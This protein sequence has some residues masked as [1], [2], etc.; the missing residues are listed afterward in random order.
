MVLSN[1]ELV[2]RVGRAE[3]FWN[4]GQYLRAFHAYRDLL[5]DVVQGK[6]DLREA[7]YNEYL[8]MDRVGDIAVLVGYTAVAI[9]LYNRLLHQAGDPV[10]AAMAAFKRLYV[11]TETGDSEPARQ[12]LTWICRRFWNGELLNPMVPD[13]LDR[14]ERSVTWPALERPA[15]FAQLYLAL[16][17]LYNALQKIEP[18]R[19]WLERGLRHAKGS[20]R[21][22]IAAVPLRIAMARHHLM[23]GDFER[24]RQSLVDARTEAMANGAGAAYALWI[25]TEELRL[26]LTQGRFSA[27]IASLKNMEGECRKHGLNRALCGVLLGRAE[28][29]I[30]LNLLEETDACLEQIHALAQSPGLED[31]RSEWVRIR[32]LRRLR[33]HVFGSQ[34]GSEAVIEMQ[35]PSEGSG[36]A[37][38]D[39]EADLRDDGV[40]WTGDCLRDYE[41]KETRFYLALDRAARSAA[42]P[43]QFLDVQ[44]IL[45]EIRE[46]FSNLPCSLIQARL[47]VLRGLVHEAC[48]RDASARSEFEQACQTFRQIGAHR[49]LFHASLHLARSVR[50]ESPALFEALVRENELRIDRLAEGLSPEMQNAFRVNKYTLV[51]EQR[52]IRVEEVV[53]LRAGCLK[54][55]WPSRLLAFIRFV[56]SLSDFIGE[57]DDE[58]LSRRKAASK[59]PSCK[60]LLGVVRRWLRHPARNMSVGYVVLPDRTFTYAVSKWRLECQVVPV[61]RL[62]IAEY[63]RQLHEALVEGPQLQYA[64]LAHR[65]CTALGLEQFLAFASKRINSLTVVPDEELAVLPFSALRF[66]RS[67]ERPQYVVE[68]FAVNIDDV[69]SR[70]RRANRESSPP[71]VAYYSG[72]EDEDSVLPCAR[73]ASGNAAEWFKHAW[74][75]ESRVCEKKL[76]CLSAL[77]GSSAFYY[78]GHGYF[79]PGEASHTGLGFAGGGRRELLSLRDLDAID[80]SGLKQAVI[81]ACH[82]ADA[83]AFH[84]RW[85]VSIPE[86]L[87]RRGAESILAPVWQPSAEAAANLSDTFLSR[88][89]T[90]GRAGALREFQLEKIRRGG[91]GAEPFE[92]AC[93]QIF[94]HPGKLLVKGRT[95][96]WQKQSPTLT[97]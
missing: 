43:R 40:V 24:C 58:Q 39:F 72:G 82:G 62:Q 32:H 18:S 22:G 34:F 33:A 56:R 77:S 21:A 91:T 47:S 55:G 8:V 45:D 35:N 5:Q 27:A 73:E 52:R 60:G 96:L 44:E 6:P 16:G 74:G 11:A 89:A 61:G 4:T 76:D 49:E 13:D 14:W 26:A 88:A 10:V 53:N 2:T 30:A 15:L 71:V 1:V 23:C 79:T 59:T 3:E 85:V 20:G 94:G 48:G 81:L 63:A 92:W 69:S 57:L 28:V 66:V 78:F 9:D 93:F 37:P 46:D 25:E 86:M 7:N 80:F 12:T 17:R 50:E 97:F 51:L 70:R 90:I 95:T 83:R 42:S 75:R 19:A 38:I 65:I 84:G 87:L 36:S 64:C 68:R 67:Q 54:G 31:I 41:A 29:L